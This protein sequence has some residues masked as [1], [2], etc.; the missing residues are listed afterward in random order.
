M[1]D[2]I[3]SYLGMT[4]APG[5]FEIQGLTTSRHRYPEMGAEVDFLSMG[6]DDFLHTTTMFSILTLWK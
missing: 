2:S 1:L 4:Q 6:H 3:V 5:S